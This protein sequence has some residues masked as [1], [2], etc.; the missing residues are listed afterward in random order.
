LENKWYIDEIYDA[1]FIRPI[2]ALAEGLWKGFDVA[3]IDRVVLGFGR[4]SAWTGQTI[5]VIQTG[6]VQVYAFMFLVGFV[7]SVGYLIYGLA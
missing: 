6:S 3:V 7:V 1:I 2:K 5:R 4:V